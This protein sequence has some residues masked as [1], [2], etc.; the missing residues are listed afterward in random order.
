MIEASICSTVASPFATMCS[1]SRHSASCSRLAMNP[2]T[3]RSMVIT[4]LPMCRKNSAVHLT[5]S[6]CGPLAAD[7][8]DQRDQVRRVE[9]VRDHQPVRRMR[10]STAISVM[11]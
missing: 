2:G 6:A 4:D 9:R 5:T 8:L 3:S 10:R 7:D 11:P 1:A